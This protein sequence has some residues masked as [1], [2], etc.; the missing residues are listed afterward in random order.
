M[1]ESLEVDEALK[2]G[3]PLD[4]FLSSLVEQHQLPPAIA[5]ALGCKA[6][7]FI[8]AAHPPLE[9]LAM[10]ALSLQSPI[11]RTSCKCPPSPAAKLPTAKFSMPTK[12]SQPRFHD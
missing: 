7:R 11:K 5:Q 3:L 6:S 4:D 10:D 2:P 1:T 9:P 12:F 8:L